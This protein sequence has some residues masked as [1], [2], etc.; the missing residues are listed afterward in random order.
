[1][2]I[3]VMKMSEQEDA[4]DVLNFTTPAERFRMLM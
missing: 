2:P 3:K 4:G 1:M